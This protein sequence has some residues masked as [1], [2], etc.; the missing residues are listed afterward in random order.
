MRSLLLKTFEMNPEDHSS[1]IL[2]D[3]AEWVSLITD[4][5]LPNLESWVGDGD[6]KKR[7]ITCAS[8]FT[9]YLLNTNVLWML[10]TGVQG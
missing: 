8:V 2:G 5:A 10:A 6:M 1:Y 3:I 4:R 7:Q 9:S